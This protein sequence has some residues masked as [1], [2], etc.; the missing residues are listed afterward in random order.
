MLAL[1]LGRRCG[2]AVLV[3]DG[4][5]PEKHKSSGVFELYRDGGSPIDD[6]KRFLAL[7]RFLNALDQVCG[8]FDVV[9]FEQVNGGTKGRQTTLWNGYRAVVMQWCEVMGKQ[10]VPLPISTI[11]KHF[12]GRA[13]AAKEEVEAAAVTLG[14][15]PY[16]D[17]EADA[18][19]TL[20]TLISLSDNRAELE[21]QIAI[22]KRLELGEFKSELVVERKR[23]SRTIC[24]TKG[25]TLDR[26]LI[27]VPS[28][29]SSEKVHTLAHQGQRKAP[30]VRDGKR[31][32]RGSG[33]GSVRSAPMPGS[34]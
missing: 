11:K 31:P 22:A 1:D 8:G 25:L 16:D 28:V 7:S 20:Y 15:L 30:V 4:D 17:N 29:Q 32:R 13:G 5:G 14:Y 33:K 10:I 21:R 12:C 6:G 2:W 18:I 34:C 23:K 24:D 9:A 27:K 26:N 3:P 19:A